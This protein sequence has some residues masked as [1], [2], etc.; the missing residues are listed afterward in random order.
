[1]DVRRIISDR[2]F[3]NKIWQS[4]KFATSKLSPDFKYDINNIKVENLSL[5]DKWILGKFE[6]C[7]AAIN[8]AFV[9]YEF[10]KLT[11]AF[12][13]FW[14]YEFCDVYLEAIKPVFYQESANTIPTQ[15][16]L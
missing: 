12:Q 6:T 10:G 14:L 3:L 16:V 2:L 4:F 8:K 11:L 15:T 5:V 13:Q 1:M 9:D 7:I